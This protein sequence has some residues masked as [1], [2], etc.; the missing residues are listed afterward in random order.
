MISEISLVNGQIPNSDILYVKIRYSALHVRI[1]DWVQENGV[2]KIV[3]YEKMRAV[4]PG[5]SAV[6][7]SGDI[8]VGGGVIL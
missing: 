3:T 6:I 4:T 8:V 2:L 1:K 5:Q 7:Y